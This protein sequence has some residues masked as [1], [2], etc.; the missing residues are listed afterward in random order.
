MIKITLLATAF[1]HLLS[2]VVY[3]QDTLMPEWKRQ[4]APEYDL[5]A[6]G[7][8]TFVMAS[9]DTLKVY[10]L[11]DGSEQWSYPLSK[12]INDAAYPEDESLF[13]FLTIE[14]KP[15]RS[16]KSVYF[17]VQVVAIQGARG[18]KRDSFLLP[19][20]YNFGDSANTRLSIRSTSRSGRFIVLSM[21][22]EVLNAGRV[23]FLY[24]RETNSCRKI[25]VAHSVS[26]SKDERSL[27]VFYWEVHFSGTNVYNNKKNTLYVLQGSDAGVERDLR[28]FRNGPLVYSPGGRVLLTAEGAYSVDSLMLI[29]NFPFA[30]R[31]DLFD[32]GIHSMSSKYD[33]YW[34]DSSITVNTLNLDRPR[35]ILSG[36]RNCMFEA[37]RRHVWSRSGSILVQAG[38]GEVNRFRIAQLRDTLIGLMGSLTDTVFEHTPYPFSAVCLPLDSMGIV[39]CSFNGQRLNYDSTIM[40][41]AGDIELLIETKTKSGMQQATRFPLRVHKLL[42]NA[43]SVW[44]GSFKNCVDAAI[45][46][47]GTGLVV[48]GEIR[49]AIDLRSDAMIHF[50]TVDLSGGQGGK[51]EPLRAGWA[52]D[53]VFAFGGRHQQVFM[54]GS[55]YTGGRSATV[56]NWFDSRTG[57]AWVQYFERWFGDND[58]D[59][60]Y[61]LDMVQDQSKGTVI[62]LAGGNDEYD[63]KVRI[64]S[65]SLALHDTTHSIENTCV[66]SVSGSADP[67]RDRRV[68]TGYHYDDL[69]MK[70]REVWIYDGEVDSCMSL[71]S[72]TASLVSFV[73][74]GRYILAD[75]SVISSNDLKVVSTGLQLHDGVSIPHT[76]LFADFVNRPRRT[77]ADTADVVL[78]E[79]PSGDSVGTF[80][81]LGGL[82]ALRI[83]SSGKH[84]MYVRND[85]IVEVVQLD[86]MLSDMGLLGMYTY[87]SDDRTY[88]AGSAF[89]SPNP[90]RELV[91][92]GHR[93]NEG[94]ATILTVTNQMGS[95]VWQWDVAASA[96]A[97]TWNLL[98][99]SGQRVAPGM[100]GFLL[101]TPDGRIVESGTFIVAPE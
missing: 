69:E 45:N 22:Q 46:P 23:S 2:A 38:S 8:N 66:I 28:G 88:R 70:G 33:R 92:F 68:Y 12:P 59:R 39:E 26:F 64:F 52:G 1:V 19:G 27:I 24:D 86:S 14:Q 97:T 80:M 84:L 73:S 67:S 9:K 4:Y 34:T 50:S 79:Y 30:K 51:S 98:T 96:S 35:W 60:S 99:S 40:M 85:A 5:M 71:P 63:G 18:V 21:S 42:R 57:Q 81:V 13:D 36:T 49:C 54:V 91:N 90:A 37:K 95:T 25:G 53:Y 83:D 17:D 15:V 72:V 82:K 77:R 31:G 20:T 10:S 29:A 65:S 78:Y 11:S 32:D 41:P 3:G 75:R 89:I 62:F 7:R 76:R 43:R 87:V 74:D 101:R 6:T 16:D 61:R 56:L 100:Y 47:S 55:R 58:Y 44:T 48:T 94:L 93:S